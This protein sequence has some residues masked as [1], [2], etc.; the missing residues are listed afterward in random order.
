MNDPN[1][2]IYYKGKYHFF[3]QYNPYHGFWENMH[4]GHAVSE[5]MLHWE[6]LPPALAP[7]EEY[8]DH[9]K[10]GCFS[11]SAIEHEGKLYL[12]YTAA[13]IMERDLSKRVYRI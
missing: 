1:G 8:E 10:G 2:V 6:Y 11:G 3:Y 7:S 4:W 13:Q 5:D 12:M 9:L